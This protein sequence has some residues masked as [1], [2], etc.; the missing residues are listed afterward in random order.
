MPEPVRLVIWDLDETFWKGT[1]TEGGIREHIKKNSEIVIELANRGIMSSICSKN[2]F[3]S[4]RDVITTLGIWDYFIFPS[5]NWESKGHRLAAIVEAVQ[6]R[7]STV[8]FIDDN[9][10]N[11]AEAERF[12]PGIQVASEGII[13]SILSSPLFQG[14]DDRQLTRLAQYKL[15]ETRHEDRAV[16]SDNRQF[17]RDSDIRVVVEHDV[18]AHLD[19]AIELINRTNQL[20]FTK[21]RLPERIEAAREM[22]STILRQ[23]DTQCGLVRVKDKYGDYGFVGIYVIRTNAVKASLLHYCFSCRTLGMNVET[24]LYDRLGRPSLNVVGDVLTD[25]LAPHDPIDWIKMGETEEATEGSFALGRILV[26]GGCDLMPIAHYLRE[27]ANEVVGEFNIVRGGLPVRCDHSAFLRYGV[28]S[29]GKSL[30]KMRAVQ[31]ISYHSDDFESA[32][33]KEPLSLNACIF[34]FWIDAFYATYE[35]AGVGLRLPFVLGRGSDSKDIRLRDESDLRKEMPDRRVYDF[36]APFIDKLREEYNYYPPSVDFLK[37]NVA[38]ILDATPVATTVIMLLAAEGMFG[39]VYRFDHLVSY[40]EAIR[41]VATGRPNVHLI[42]I[43][44]CVQ[45]AGEMQNVLH[46]DRMVY[47]RL[48]KRISDLLLGAKRR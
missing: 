32:L 44:D 14:K 4:V 9:P 20:N 7:P 2:D 18:V 35:N 1:L 26:R 23:Y 46:Y 34:S 24:W 28:E 16:Y 47:F 30:S 41:M 12:V 8:L 5:V 29:A 48:F 19:R 27:H 39:S 31:E 43:M 40:N 15:L 37:E 45:E 13:D 42:S 36:A 33:T 11:L 6:L 3:N 21:L 10:M 22:L 25:I 38:K 17:L